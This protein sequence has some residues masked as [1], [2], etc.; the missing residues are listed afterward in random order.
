MLGW[1]GFKDE[2]IDEL[3]ARGSYAKAAAALR[4]EFDAGRRDPAL[5]QQLGDVL[6][7]AGKTDEAVPILLGV[8]DELA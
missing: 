2:R 7:L 6:L 5:R 4:K 8:A 3:V 1:L